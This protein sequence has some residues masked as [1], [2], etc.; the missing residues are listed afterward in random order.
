MILFRIPLNTLKFCLCVLYSIEFGA[1]CLYFTYKSSLNLIERNIPYDISF[2]YDDVYQI[3]R[4]FVA[5]V[6]L[7]VISYD[8]AVRYNYR[9]DQLVS[10]NLVC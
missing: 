5:Y 4:N 9:L 6:Y 2:F 8:D 3:L 7:L 10:R 1:Q